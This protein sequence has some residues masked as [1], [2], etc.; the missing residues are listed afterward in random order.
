M[1]KQKSIIISARRAQ[2]FECE[3]RLSALARISYL[4][5]EDYANHIRKKAPRAQNES[6]AG[7]LLLADML[8]F[9]SSGSLFPI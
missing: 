4:F 5:G 3:E 1:N 6:I 7:A 2:A 8:S 9:F